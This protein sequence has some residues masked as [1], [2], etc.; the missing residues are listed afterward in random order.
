MLVRAHTRTH[1]RARTH[2]HTHTHTHTKCLDQSQG[3][4]AAFEKNLHVEKSRKIEV[5]KKM[6]AFTN[7]LELIFLSFSGIHL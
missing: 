5:F 6:S 2:T 3:L 4:K 1:A 7:K